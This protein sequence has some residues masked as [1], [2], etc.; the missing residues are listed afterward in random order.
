M[1]FVVMLHFVFFVLP[2]LQSH[3]LSFSVFFTELMI[4]L[5]LAIAVFEAYNVLKCLQNTLLDHVVKVSK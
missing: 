1:S 2:N 5:L 4:K 3:F